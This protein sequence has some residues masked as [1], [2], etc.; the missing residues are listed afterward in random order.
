MRVVAQFPQSNIEAIMSRIKAA[1]E[2]R[3]ASLNFDELESV[4]VPFDAFCGLVRRL[5]TGHCEFT[6]HDIITLARYYQHRPDLGLT[7]N[8]M[9]AI[10]HE[11]LKRASWED[12]DHIEYQCEHHDGLRYL[13]QLLYYP[14]SAFHFFW[15]GNA[16]CLSV[17]SRY[18]I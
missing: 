9:L 1:L 5:L 15:V 2:P 8:E 13:E 3:R 10:C 14:S 16:G 4:S 12:F 11:Q 18:C 6:N 7:V 17:M